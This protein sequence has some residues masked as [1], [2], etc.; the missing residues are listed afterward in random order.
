MSLSG[1]RTKYVA[2]IALI[3]SMIIWSASGIAIKQALTVF[4]P[5]TLIIM[6]F[7]PSV[8]IMFVIGIIFRKSELFGL[9][10]LALK[11]LP[12]IL[13]AGFC[14]PFLYYLLEIFTYEALDSPTIAEALLSTGPLVAP[15]FAALMLRE[16]IT[17]NNIIGILISTA[18]VLAMVLAGKSN[19]SIG[20]YWGVLLAFIA[21]S[22]AVMDSIMIRK[23]PAHYTPLS[24]IFYGQLISLCFFVPL[25]LWREGITGLTGVDWSAFGDVSDPV[26]QA[27][28][29]IRYLIVFASVLAFILFC[30]ALRIVGVTE[31]NAF[32]NIRP[33]FTAMWMILFFGEQLPFAKWA[34]I[35]LII[36]GLFIC[37]KQEKKLKTQ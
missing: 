34:G 33:V 21:V 20:N 35:I 36:L 31:A 8:F 18:G 25:W 19:Y 2:V 1:N 28:L 11:D 4:Q 17:R 23:M 14:Q 6:R 15:V 5:L 12:I 26:T 27:F 37:Q 30:Y 10:K 32:N 7:V 22:A 13:V 3:V 16:R 24:I 29:Y 9:Q